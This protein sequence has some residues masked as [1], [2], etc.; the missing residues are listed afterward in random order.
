MTNPISA[1]E[2]GRED[3]RKAAVAEGTDMP[4]A[5]VVE[6]TTGPSSIR[7]KE[8]NLYRSLLQPPKEFQSGFTWTTIAGALFCGLLMMPGSIYLSL[9][10]GGA[11]NA[12]WVTV[13][14]FTEV[15]RRALKTLRTQELVV[16]L[17]VAGA[18]A[19]GGPIA[20]L[21]YRQYFVGSDAVK[22]IGLF[23]KFPAWWAPQPNSLAILER[24]LFHIEW[25]LPILLILF[26]A[27]IN[28][29][30]GYTLGYFFFRLTSDV[31]RLPFP[32]APIQASGAMALAESGE[33][34]Q[35]W[36]W[37]V[38]SIGAIIG[39]LFATVQIGIPLITG[40]MLTTSVQ[41]IPLPWYDATT[42][43]QSILPAT[44]TGIVI[45][46][47][48][49]LFGMVMPF[50]AVMGVAAA[51][52][53]TFV[54]NPLLYSMG[55]L[56]RWQPGMDTINTSWCN[57]VDFWM[58]FGMGVTLGI[59]LIAFYQTGRDLI[60]QVR[61]TR[62]R[63]R[64]TAS[65]VAARENIWGTPPA[66]RGD[67][68]PWVAMIVYFAAALTVV[69]MCYYLL[70]V[71]PGPNASPGAKNII[72][73]LLFFTLIYTP[74]FTYI[75]TRLR[76]INGQQ[77]VIPFLRE[78]AFLLSGFK[79][80]E[81]WL[82]PLPLGDQYA[83]QAES[84][85]VTELT[86]T[87]F[88]SYVKANLIIVPLSLVLSLLF[89]TFIWH[90]N[91]IPS[92]NFPWAQ[93]MWDLQAKT[94]VLAYSMTLPAGGAQP[95][96][97]Q[98]LQPNVAGGGYTGGAVVGGS[99]LVFTIIMFSLLSHFHLPTMAVYGFLM[100]IGQMPHGQVFLIFGALLG[101]FY[102]QKRYGQTQFLQMVPVVVAG[103]T[104]GVGLIA[105]IGVAFN[106]IIKAISPAP[107]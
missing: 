70:V 36:K 5:I 4:D 43:T 25:L 35:T 79:G 8:I 91:A 89:W 87:N 95:L 90:S 13:I 96:F 63:R 102:F 14:I 23:G 59:A 68:S 45:D 100:G 53:L 16:L 64:E 58:V 62:R 20:E 28:A 73:F 33:R 103:Y 52:L 11:I 9:I 31:E 37:R 44:P 51:V 32:F 92:E 34:K 50:W 2:R 29:V 21:I 67:F 106:L 6:E 38:F 22:D 107:F 56:H 42:A 77:V 85:R 74:F 46:L 98:A 81:V 105:L 75:N 76:A 55:V 86:G 10:T 27:V 3:A 24:N 54:M 71:Y 7:D 93:K 40:A 104:T 60:R 80:V 48:L 1:E 41:L 19:T 61:E 83:A 39:L 18:M 65:G 99:A 88:W 78:G 26:L 66:N 82:A 12:S 17:Y 49:L 30:K 84:F 101:R 97:F 47:G 57:T 72:W 94:Q 15:S 69:G